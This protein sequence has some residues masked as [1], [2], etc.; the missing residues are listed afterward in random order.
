MHRLF[1]ILRSL[2][3]SEQNLNRRP[4]LP[5]ND[6]NFH[7][8]EARRAEGS[9]EI[10]RSLSLPQNDKNVY[11]VILS[12]GLRLLRMTTTFVILKPEGLKDLMCNNFNYE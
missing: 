10:L 7:H 5:Q 2:G 8:P 9:Y 1:K 12:E 4:A 3:L 11:N 6:D